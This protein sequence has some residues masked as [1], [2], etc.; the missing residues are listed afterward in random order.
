M[1]IYDISRLLTPDIAVW[2]G[3]SRFSLETVLD[4]GQGASVNLTTLIMSA[5]TGAHIDAPRHYTDQGATVEQVSL[6]Y[7]WGTAQV[8]SL[9]PEQVADGPIMPADLAGVDLSLAQRLLLHTHCSHL[10]LT[11]FPDQIRYPSPELAE[12]LGRAGI[13]L[14]GNDAPS[15][16][17][18]DSKALPGHNALL[19]NGVMI[20]EGIDLSVVPDGLYELA[21]LPLKIGGGDGS[22]V[23]AALRKLQL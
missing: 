13:V 16:D 3:D 12:M 11:V 4:R 9:N 19:A 20:L 8:V 2:P 6:D 14:L 21:A 22:P 10:D 7:Y 18:I 23:R 15:M 1:T 5:H 17:A